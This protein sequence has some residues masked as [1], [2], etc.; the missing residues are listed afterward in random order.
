MNENIIPSLKLVYK[1]LIMYYGE[2][3][4]LNGLEE[5]A[6]EKRGKN[7]FEEFLDR[8]YYMPLTVL[9][10]DEQ[11]ARSFKYAISSRLSDGGRTLFFSKRAFLRNVIS[12]A[13]ELVDNSG[14]DIYKEI[15][16]A[17]RIR[18]DI[19]RDVFNNGEN[20]IYYD[21]IKSEYIN[22]ELDMSLDEYVL[23]CKKKYT[24]L[25][26]GYNAV[27]DLL[28][29]SI[30]VDKF[31]K[32]FDVDRLY[33]HTVYSLLKHSEE[34][35]EAYG[36]LDYNIIVLDSYKELVTDL[37]KK[38]S[39]YNSYITINNSVYTIDDLFKEYGELVMKVNEK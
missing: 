37:R 14:E 33:L 26:S 13:D 6:L 17:I 34:Y 39:F 4:L 19:Y 9:F 7:V 2:W 32:C 15:K 35:Y 24:K 10:K 20:S 36:K 8:Y 5:L 22:C 3:E 28:D 23:L 16:K 29:K 18:K 30:N 1:P 27:L 38:D 31:I 11:L 12:N 21:E 25:L